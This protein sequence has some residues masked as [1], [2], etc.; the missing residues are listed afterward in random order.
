MVKHLGI[1]NFE[2]IVFNNDYLDIDQ[3]SYNKINIACDVLN[4]KR[5]N[6]DID[7]DVLNKIQRKNEEIFNKHNV[8]S[9]SGSITSSY[10]L[11]WAWKNYLSKESGPIFIIDCDMFFIK[12]TD[13][14]SL[15]EYDI[16][17]VHQSKENMEYMWSGICFL[18]MSKLENPDEIN[19]SYGSIDNVFLDTG[20][21]TSL[22]LKKYKNDKIRP[23]NP[24]IH[25]SNEEGFDEINYEKFRFIDDEFRILHYRSGSNWNNKS[26]DYHHKKTEWLKNKLLC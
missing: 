18:N 11:C 14:S 23:F 4:I 7:I 16:L 1:G 25:I 22:Y 17:Y 20:G 12:D 26:D 21:L 24:H 3:D 9:G 10:A 13:L 15:L 6:I 5:I 8:Y 19:W 2:L